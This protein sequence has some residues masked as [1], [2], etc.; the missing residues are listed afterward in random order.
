MTT[1]KPLGDI[2]TL[3]TPPAR[4]PFERYIGKL[5]Y[6]EDIMKYYIENGT[7][8]FTIHQS[9]NDRTLHQLLFACEKEIEGQRYIYF[10]LCKIIIS[11]MQN[12]IYTS[13][14]YFRTKMND[15]FMNAGGYKIVDR[16]IDEGYERELPVGNGIS[17]EMKQYDGRI[18]IDELHGN[19]IFVNEEGSEDVIRM[20]I[21]TD[22]G[23]YVVAK[24]NAGFASILNTQLKF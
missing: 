8:K 6:N 1:R 5:R 21:I 18:K 4:A 10:H 17:Y 13:G 11:S 22:F 2:K 9:G 20:K 23:L 3:P 15:A 16:F 14:I 24:E 12:Y 19:Y 7:N